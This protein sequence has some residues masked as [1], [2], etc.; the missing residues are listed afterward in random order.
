MTAIEMVSDRATKK[1]V[2]AV[3]A[4]IVQDTAYDNGAMV[5]VSGPNLIL[6]PSLVLTEADAQTLLDGIEAGFKVA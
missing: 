3:R 1:P 6:S 4:Q 2:D 5:R